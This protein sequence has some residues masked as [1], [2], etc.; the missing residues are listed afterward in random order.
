MDKNTNDFFE[1]IQE[2]LVKEYEESEIKNLCIECGVDMGYCNPR[3]YCG[4][5]YCMNQTEQIEKN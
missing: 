4:K 1:K 5:T 3:Q 2:E